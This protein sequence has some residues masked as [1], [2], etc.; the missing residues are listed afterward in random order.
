M[1]WIESIENIS[2]CFKKL[3]KEE[4][5]LF[6]NKKTQVTFLKGET[7]FKQGAFASNVLFIN[8]GMVMTYLQLSSSKQI[9]L[10]LAV[11][12]DYL[13]FSTIFETKTHQYS[14]MAIT[15][16]VVCMIDI[17]AFRNVILRNPEF[18]MEIISKNNSNSNRY[19]EI[20][21]NI[22]YKQMRGKLASAIL[23]LSADKFKNY[24]IFNKLTRN[25]IA[26]F[27]SITVEST[28]KFLKEFEK[29][30]LIKLNGKEI[31]ILDEPR[32][33]QIELKG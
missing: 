24:D 23:Y 7:I 19:L 9:N 8:R 16:T 18:G 29:D 2:G 27:A 28:V 1:D 33:K 17:M 21:K 6:Y 12:G 20:I 26:N 3:S 32:L 15:E 25:D 31:I 14:A 4:L 10:Q 5:S 11:K 22:A 13:S 30:G